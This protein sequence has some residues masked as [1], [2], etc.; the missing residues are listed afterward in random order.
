MI[1]PSS[2]VPRGRDGVSNDDNRNDDR[3]DNR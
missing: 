2:R 1:S 3:E